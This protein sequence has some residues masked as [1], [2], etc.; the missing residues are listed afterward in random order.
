MKQNS[1]KLKMVRNAI[2]FV[3]LNLS[4][5]SFAQI[6]VKFADTTNALTMTSS[7]ISDGVHN[8]KK[9]TITIP[10][11]ANHLNAFQFKTEYTRQGCGYPTQNYVMI[12]VNGFN[13]QYQS[14]Y[15]QSKQPYYD[16]TNLAVGSYP[17]IIKSICNL[18]EIPNSIERIIIEVVKEPAPLLNLTIASKCGTNK[19]GLFTGY[20]EFNASG[21]YTNASKIYITATNSSNG[22]PTYAEVKLTQLSNNSNL[23]NNTL[24]NSTFY[25]CNSNGTYTVKLT[26]RNI[27]IKNKPISHQIL[28][29][30][31]G[32]NGYT[33]KK[34]FRNCMNVMDPILVP[35]TPLKDT[36]VEH[37]AGITMKNPVQNEVSF[38]L[39]SDE[40][41]NYEVQIYD[42]SGLP[43]KRA[44][45]KAINSKTT[46]TINVQDL[47]KGIYLVEITNGDSV[48]RKK[49]IKE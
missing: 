10:Y 14:I 30:D 26:Y 35:F 39:S 5:S 29:P 15:D 16:I 48:I 12:N 9:L 31:N 28:P 34:S 45:F 6:Q 47:K 38:I 21:S 23:P 20:I 32:W 27:T 18:S 49:M 36:G 2:L 22:C 24:S 1:L 8:W 11:F 33:F 41:A 19:K 43:V 42:F 4:I 37:E 13:S 25:S 44:S 40:K 7:I 3:L 17:Y 46:N